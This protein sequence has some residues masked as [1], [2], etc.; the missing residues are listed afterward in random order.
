MIPKFVAEWF[1]SNKEYLGVAF[2]FRETTYAK[3]PLDERDDIDNWFANTDDVMDI[4]V[5]MK[6]GYEIEKEK[7]YIVQLPTNCEDGLVIL[8][9][10]GIIWNDAFPSEYKMTEQRIKDIDERYWA[11]AVEVAE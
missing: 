1:E 7:L 6:N 4:L 3:K 5:S 9:V 8:D 2:A 11:F 10:R